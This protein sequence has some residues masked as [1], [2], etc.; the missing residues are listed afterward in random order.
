MANF[1]NITVGGILKLKDTSFMKD[2]TLVATYRN[3]YARVI[4]KDESAGTI[5]IELFDGTLKWVKVERVTGT[6]ELV[7]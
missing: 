3:T 5:R 2:K 4:A 6:F 1:E 7:E